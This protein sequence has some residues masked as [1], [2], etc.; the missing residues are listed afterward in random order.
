MESTV[1]ADIQRCLK[2]WARCVLAF[3]IFSSQPVLITVKE[4]YLGLVTKEADIG[5]YSL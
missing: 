5:R 2:E 1:W 3:M 4:E